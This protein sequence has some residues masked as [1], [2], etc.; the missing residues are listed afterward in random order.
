MV[1]HLYELRTFHENVDGIVPEHPTSKY[2]Q[3]NYHSSRRHPR[4]PIRRGPLFNCRTDS[5]DG[6]L[7]SRK[8]AMN[9]IR[10]RSVVSPTVLLFNVIR[11]RLSL[12]PVD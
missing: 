9:P 12:F 8:V 4:E 10:I 7:S 6:L 11:L 3:M 5:L 1:D 2:I